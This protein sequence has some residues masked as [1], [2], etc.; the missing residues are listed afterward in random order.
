MAARLNKFLKQI[1][2]T[3]SN[4]AVAEVLA[5]NAPAA[6]AQK[7]PVSQKTTPSAPT[8]TTAP[9][10]A[11]MKKGREAMQEGAY[12][13][14]LKIFRETLKHSNDS[15]VFNY[16]G[17]CFYMTG[18]HERSARAF[19]EA[20]KQD[21]KRANNF[22][23]LG[24]ALTKQKKH[25]RAFNVFRR[26]IQ[27]DNKN[28]SYLCDYAMCCQ[29]LVGKEKYMREEALITFKKAVEIDPKH[30]ES[31]FR[32]GNLY[33]AD[34]DFK[35]A[36]NAYE[37]TL[38]L[39]SHR[40]FA[41]NNLVTAYLRLEDYDPAERLCRKVL[42]KDPKDFIANY[43]MGHIC[44]VKRRFTD[45]KIFYRAAL[46]ARPQ[47]KNA[48]MN[49]GMCQLSE[50][51]L[52]EAEKSYRHVL[53]FEPNNIEIGKIL[54]RLSI[55]HFSYG[56]KRKKLNDLNITETKRNIKAVDIVFFY[57]QLEVKTT[58]FEKKDYFELLHNAMDSAKAAMPEATIKV[59]TDHKTQFPRNLPIDEVLRYDVNPDEVISEAMR[60]KRAYLE[61]YTRP[62]IFAD[63][64]IIFNQDIRAIFKK[65]FDIGL[66]WRDIYLF[67]PVNTG[68]I[69]INNKNK[70]KVRAFYDGCLDAID[71]LEAFGR[72]KE[73]FNIGIRHWWGDQL[74]IAAY[75][76]WKE[77]LI[78]PST[79]FDVDG[80][81]VLFFPGKEYNYTPEE[82]RKYTVK[83]LNLK[84]CLHF[85]GETKD[86]M[87]QFLN[88]KKEG[89]AE[90]FKIETR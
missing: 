56:A 17:R 46:K 38:S 9:F 31:W 11:L 67:M 78:R 71:K 72:E 54:S 28:A 76:G 10:N 79:Y 34:L 40:G 52:D 63:P 90:K 22:A 69:F 75:V 68:V 82:G 25:D 27:L 70:A 81:K 61:T 55:M 45:A 23:N 16:I 12:K 53:T 57:T 7:A 85:K 5:Q 24:K 35:D 4:D 30:T 15:L 43:N 51:R 19:M 36:Q 62:T 6:P 80:S 73:E 58:P 64:D 74:S 26:A 60:V 14:A 50:Y 47:Y 89:S 21:P 3:V 66:T 49:L 48:W 32:L 18:E 87:T 33:L 59:L 2:K 42:E 77:C 20:I 39:E 37:K 83:E 41:I 84:N 29:R 86:F 1:K 8:E 44:K 13:E 88:M 65:D